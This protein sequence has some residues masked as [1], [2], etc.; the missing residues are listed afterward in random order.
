M[1]I[2]I[3]KSALMALNAVLYA[4][5]RLKYLLLGRPIEKC[6]DLVTTSVMRHTD[7]EAIRFRN[8]NPLQVLEV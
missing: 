6:V 3:W 8:D 7:V 4:F 1:S 5:N 2:G